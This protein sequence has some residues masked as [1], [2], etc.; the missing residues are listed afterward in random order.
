[1]LYKIGR[2]ATA[3]ISASS[4]FEFLYREVTLWRIDTYWSHVFMS[5][6][7][8]EFT[9]LEIWNAVKCK[10]FHMNLRFRSDAFMCLWMEVNGTKSAVW[11]PLHCVHLCNT[12]FR[13]VIIS[14]LAL[15]P[16]MLVSCV[17]VY[18][19]V[20]YSQIKPA[21][22]VCCVYCLSAPFWDIIKPHLGSHNNLSVDILLQSY[23]HCQMRMLIF[24]SSL[25]WS[26]QPVSMYCCKY[27]FL[28]WFVLVT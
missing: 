17:N 3:K 21:S 6:R 1:M 9:K 2:C 16:V 11:P 4:V 18:V 12:G 28:W 19:L 27:N 20:L 14:C 5:Y 8:S 23:T 15:L 10:N 22:H 7:R 13:F 24:N 25:Y 26:Q